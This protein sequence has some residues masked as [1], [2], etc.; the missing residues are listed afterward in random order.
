MKYTDKTIQNANLLLPLLLERGELTGSEIKDIC[1]LKEYSTKHI[2]Y[3]IAYL[4]AQ[5]YLIYEA[6]EKNSRVIHYGLMRRKN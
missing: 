6:T 2:D 4:E 5:G 3:I 1:G